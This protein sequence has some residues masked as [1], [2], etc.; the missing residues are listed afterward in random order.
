MYKHKTINKDTIMAMSPNMCIKLFEEQQKEIER[1]SRLV[2]KQGKKINKYQ[3]LLKEVHC[4]KQEDTP[5]ICVPKK[6]EPR[7]MFAGSG[8]TYG[9]DVY[10]EDGEIIIE[11]WGPREGGQLYKGEYKGDA[12]PYLLDIKSENIQLYNSIVKFFANRV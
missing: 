9:Y 3:K 11:H 1:L 4:G 12:T 8:R 7:H 5:N 2:E 10:F 6:K